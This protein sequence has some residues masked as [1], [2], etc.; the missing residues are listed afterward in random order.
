VSV[1]LDRNLLTRIDDTD[2]MV[3]RAFTTLTQLQ[4][5]K[6]GM[7]DEPVLQARSGSGSVMETIARD[8]D[9]PILLA[10]LRDRNG[11]MQYFSYGINIET[12]CCHLAVIS[13][14]LCQDGMK[15]LP[16]YRRNQDLAMFKGRCLADRARFY[17]GVPI[18]D[19][20]GNVIGSLAILQESRLIATLGFSLEKMQ[21]QGKR[22]MAYVRDEA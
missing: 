7:E 10:A 14:T 8:L 16:D 19:G 5:R 2:Q 9:V 13:D 6:N 1:A 3:R 15:I 21:A 18:R 11:I 17:V 12:D 22:L 4:R 20:E